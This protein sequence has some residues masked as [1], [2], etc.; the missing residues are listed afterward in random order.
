MILHSEPLK[1]PYLNAIF[2]RNVEILS[3]PASA[4][5]QASASNKLMLPSSHPGPAMVTVL[6]KPKVWKNSKE[7]FA[8]V[9]KHNNLKHIIG[10]QMRK[11]QRVKIEKTTKKGRNWQGQSP[12]E[13]RHKNNRLVGILRRDNNSPPNSLGTLFLGR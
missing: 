3:L 8:K 12:D 4:K 9:N 11:V 2:Q 7:I 13:K 10:I 1:A 6:P 5:F